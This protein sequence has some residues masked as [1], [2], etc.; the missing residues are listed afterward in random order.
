[1]SL[2]KL[3]KMSDAEIKNIIAHENICRIA[4]I[5]N[6][7][8]YIAP[9]QYIV[10]DDSLYFHF[11]NYGKKM[12][13]LENNNH[14]CVS[15]ESFHSDLSYYSFISIQGILERVIQAQDIKKIAE[16]LANAASEKFSNSFLSVHGFDREKGWKELSSKSDLFIY[17]LKETGE[18]IGLR[19]FK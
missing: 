9:F 15:I 7:Y 5:D 17:K 10:E 12:E 4:F 19:S 6:D 14:V 16:K 3:P 18:R 1:M 8:P 13:I 2:V 11:T